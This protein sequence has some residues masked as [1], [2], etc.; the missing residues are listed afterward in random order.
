MLRLRDPGAPARPG[1]FCLA[2]GGLTTVAAASNDTAVA[3]RVQP[4]ICIV[5]ALAAWLEGVVAYGA[6]HDVITDC[7]LSMTGRL[8]DVLTSTADLVL[9][10][11]LGI[12]SL[13]PQLGGTPHSWRHWKPM[14][15]DAP[16]IVGAVLASC[17]FAIS[18]GARGQ[19]M[20]CLAAFGGLVQVGV[21]CMDAA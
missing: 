17:G 16:Y 14:A 8:M 21:S 19:V 1:I 7:H 3:G 2:A 15:H 5:A 9:G 13:Q 11:A 12:H 4:A 10:V 6:V 18:A 20:D